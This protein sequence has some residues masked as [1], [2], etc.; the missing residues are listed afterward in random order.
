MRALPGVESAA[1]VNHLPIGGDTWRLGVS[2]E[3]R[4]APDAADGPTAIIRTASAGYLRA[5]GVPLQRGRALDER[6]GPDGEPVVLVNEAFARR[7]LEG[8]D[9]TGTRVKLGGVD[10][11]GPW[12]A[13][14]GVIGDA[15]QASLVDPVQPEILF[16]Y[17]QDPVGWFEGTTL[18]VR[19]GGDPSALAGPVEAQLRAAAPELPVPRTR[20]MSEVLAVAVGQDRFNT[21]LLAV[22]A[23][24]ALLLAAAGIYAVMA[25]A[26]ARRRHE[27]GVRL[28]LGARAGTV[29]G[30]VV[31]DGLRLA[32]CGAAIG[33]AGAL[34]LTRLLRAVLHDVSPTDPAT[35]ALSALVLIGVAA[36]ASF[37]PARRAARVDP[38][39]ALRDA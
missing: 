29:L 36:A 32:L 16:P 33:L 11:A 20:T 8:K 15:R 4:P 18:V 10:A 6:D 35:F 5:L 17:G 37:F 7:Y 22:L 34:A 2:I 24:V 30:M 12:R 13:V 39:V 38:L 27:I 23:S 1:F 28:A 26:V 19:T 25:Y 14:V 3:G 9:A 21:L 31:R